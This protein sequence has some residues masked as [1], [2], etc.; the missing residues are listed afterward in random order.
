MVATVIATVAVIGLAY[1]FSLG[2][3]FIDRFEVARAALNIAQQRLELMHGNLDP[4]AWA[5]SLHQ[6][7]FNYSGRE[8]GLEEWTVSWYDDPGTSTTTQD[9]KRVTVSV[10]WSMGGQADTVSLNRLFLP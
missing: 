2:R 7:P 8:I 3:S 5:D 6:R 9:L 1:S 10:S 4:E